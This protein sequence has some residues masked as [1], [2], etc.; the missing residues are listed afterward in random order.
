MAFVHRRR[1]RFATPPLDLLSE[2]V[3]PLLR[4]S[5]FPLRLASWKSL[6]QLAA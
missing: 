3:Q 2:A 6:L 4:P 1:A 5:L